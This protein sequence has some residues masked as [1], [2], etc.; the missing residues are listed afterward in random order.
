MQMCVF[1]FRLSQFGI[2][3]NPSDL[4]CTNSAMDKSLYSVERQILLE[5]LREAR[6]AAGISQTKLAA[7]LEWTQG[8]VSKAEKGDRTLDAVELR[9]WVGH[10]GQDLTAFIELWEQRIAAHHASLP[11]RTATRRVRKG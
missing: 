5:L 7:S 6:S 2:F 8:M 4:R 1:H 9:E 11:H 3:F 10:L